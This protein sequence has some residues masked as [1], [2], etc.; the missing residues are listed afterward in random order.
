MSKKQKP[1]LNFILNNLDYNE[2][3]PEEF[4]KNYGMIPLTRL[5]NDLA[6]EITNEKGRF[7][8]ERLPK[9]IIGWYIEATKFIGKHYSP[10]N[11]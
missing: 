5:Y 4:A 11:R 6:Q 7:I 2:R 1:T 10:K 3:D 9:T 8:E